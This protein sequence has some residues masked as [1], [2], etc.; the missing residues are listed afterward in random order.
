ML[1]L[2]ADGQPV[3]GEALT[4]LAI[5]MWGDDLARMKLRA[6]EEVDAAAEVARR[7]FITP[8][9]GQAMEYLSTE[10]E[11]RDFDAGGVGPWP[12]LE[13]ERDAMGGGVTLAQV[14][15]VVQAQ[16]AAWRAVGGE[17]KRL[18]RAAKMEIEAALT[19]AEVA[20]ATVIAWP[21]P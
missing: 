18:R 6:M 3:T 9:S 5:R 10:T 1:A 11:A 4:A 15:A 16:V 17:I 19:P 13:A 21:A 14:A 12:F 2:D 20:T 8:G 7:R